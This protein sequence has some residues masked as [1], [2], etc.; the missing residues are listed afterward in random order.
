MSLARIRLRQCCHSSTSA[1]SPFFTRRSSIAAL[2]S[3]FKRRSDFQDHFRHNKQEM[4]SHAKAPGPFVRWRLKHQGDWRQ[5][6]KFAF[7]F[8]AAILSLNLLFIIVVAAKAT[9]ESTTSVVI[10]DGICKK[11]GRYSSTFHFVINAASSIVLAS[12]SYCLQCLS[13]PTRDDV[14]RAHADKTWMDIGILSFR[15]VRR[16]STTRRGLWILL[17][18]SSLPLH[19]LFNSVVFTTISSS[20]YD[21]YSAP[22][23]HEEALNRISAWPNYQNGSLVRLDNAACITAYSR[24]YHVGWGDVIV[25]SNIP[26]P[27]YNVSISLADYDWMCASAVD[28]SV[29]CFSYLSNITASNWTYPAANYRVTSCLAEVKEEHCRLKASLTLLIAVAVANIAKLVVIYALLLAEE[30]PL[31]TLGDSIASFISTPD[32]YTSGRFRSVELRSGGVIGRVAVYDGKLQK[33]GSVPLLN[34]KPLQLQG[35]ELQRARFRGGRLFVCGA[36]TILL[37]A[38]LLAVYFPS[39][40]KQYGGL[41]S[42][43]EMKQLGFGPSDP[44][45][46]LQWGDHG[47]AGNVLIANAGQLLF[48]MLYFSYNGMLTSVSVAREWNN[49]GLR[50]KGL[51]VSEKPR[52]AQRSTYFLSLPYR[53]AAPLLLISATMHWLLSQSIFFINVDGYSRMGVHDPALDIT[54]VGLSPNALL[55]VMVGLVAMLVFMGVVNALRLRAKVPYVGSCSVLIAVACHPSMDE[56]DEMVTRPLCLEALQEHAEDDGNGSYRFTPGS[57]DGGQKGLL[58]EGEELGA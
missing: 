47:F 38:L 30:R 15:N 44:A 31:L 46:Q 8:T 25:F 7:I 6:V 12:S 51:R 2:F 55:A 39:M 22:T 17:V 5:S 29:S 45:S 4:R 42:F 13:A 50:P 11:A 18:L 23:G 57:A 21:I 43:Q 36:I 56:K 20:E 32:A 53:F 24:G 54:T 26:E 19:L 27:V 37:L 33:R 49:F 40:Q 58:R 28:L 3:P 9:H 34:S 1:K 10:Y 14:D 16:I 35:S 48:S 52:Q 41:L